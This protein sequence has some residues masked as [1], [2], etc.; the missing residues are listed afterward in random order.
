VSEGDLAGRWCAGDRAALGEAFD[1]Y[2][3][4]I[5]RYCRRRTVPG[6]PDD[7][8][9]LMS[10]TFLDAWAA[11]ERAVVIDGSLRPWLLG[12][13]ANVLRHQRRSLHRHRSALSRCPTE[14]PGEDATASV[15]RAVD[16]AQRLP[17]VLRDLE[18]LSVKEREVV[19]LLA[20]EG[21]SIASVARVLGV[22]QG[23]IRSRLARARQRLGR[24]GDL[25]DTTDSSGHEPGERA[26]HAPTSGGLA[27]NH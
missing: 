22:P 10:V 6:G 14:P 17:D 7:A 16:A 3:Q 13:A 18:R 1:A 4:V 24:P 2:A 26:P 20:I 19:E 15:E 27:W 9:D 5:Y 23:T 11:R 25:T 12:V 21:L 8:E